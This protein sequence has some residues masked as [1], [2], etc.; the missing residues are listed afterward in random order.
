M[1]AHY[2]PICEDSKGKQNTNADQVINQEDLG[3]RALTVCSIDI[4]EYIWELL[5]SACELADERSYR[6]H[7]FLLFINKCKRSLKSSNPF[8]KSYSPTSD[9]KQMTQLTRW[10]ATAL[11]SLS[12]LLI[13]THVRSVIEIISRFIVFLIILTRIRRVCLARGCI[14]EDAMRVIVSLS[15]LKE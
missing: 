7:L 2:F 6:V 3:V 12:H 4:A 11:V 1:T 13:M 9:R 15:C 14:Q 5:L 10:L 8:N